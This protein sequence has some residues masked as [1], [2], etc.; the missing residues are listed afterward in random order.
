MF[1]SSIVFTHWVLRFIFWCDA[2]ENIKKSSVRASHW[3]PHMK[4]F[5]GE[6]ELWFLYTF[7][8]HIFAKILSGNTLRK[9][10]ISLNFLKKIRCIWIKIS[11]LKYWNTN[12]PSQNFLLTPEHHFKFW[13]LKKSLSVECNQGNLEVVQ[14]VTGGQTNKSCKKWN[15]FYWDDSLKKNLNC[16]PQ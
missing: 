16:R 11:H 14:K 3:V 10:F 2:S 6:T 9:Y 5:W 1:Q 13:F 12:V 8:P 4:K 15:L 7:L